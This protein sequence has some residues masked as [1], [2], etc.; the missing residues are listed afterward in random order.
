V[1]LA[2]RKLRSFK[3]KK[4]KGFE[5]DVALLETKVGGARKE[6]NLQKG[7]ELLDD[8]E[9]LLSQQKIESA[10]QRLKQVE[11]LHIADLEPR[12]ESIKGRLTSL[13]NQNNENVG[14]A[15]SLISSARL[16]I[17]RGQIAQA[18][19]WLSQAR[20]LGV[21]ELQSE[22][23]SLTL[24]AK[25]ANVRTPGLRGFAL[26]DEALKRG[27]W[28][29]AQKI[30]KANQANPPAGSETRIADLSQ[31]IKALQPYVG[32]GV[33]RKWTDADTKQ[34][35]V[36][37]GAVVAQV[38]PGSPADRSG[39]KVGDVLIEYNGNVLVDE[40]QLP[41]LGAYSKPGTTVQLK[42][43]RN[44]ERMNIR[45]PVESSSNR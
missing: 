35:G 25:N 17:Q 4:F 37:F 10:S 40:S 8:A 12:I 45:I 36:K 34:S 21:P 7:T 14:K 9:K 39:L 32:L 42:I 23:D 19:Q 29:E 26:A 13:R 41:W 15:K 31:R 24:Q 43:I 33:R 27:D 2:E 6:L 18:Q 1:E 3:N 30:L 11:S 5:N 38:D 22:I 20:S 44:G 16:L 28:I